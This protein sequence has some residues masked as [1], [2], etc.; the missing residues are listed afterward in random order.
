MVLLLCTNYSTGKEEGCLYLVLLDSFTLS[1]LV[2]KLEVCYRRKEI[3]TSDITSP[4]LQCW[5]FLCVLYISKY[6]THSASFGSV[7]FFYTQSTTKSRQSSTLG[8]VLL[9]V[10]QKA[11]VSTQSF[12]LL[13]CF[14]R[15][16]SEFYNSGISKIFVLYNPNLF[17][18]M[19][20]LISP[21][22]RQW[23]YQLKLC[24][25]TAGVCPDVIGD[26]LEQLALIPCIYHSQVRDEDIYNIYM[27]WHHLC[28]VSLPVSLSVLSV[29]HRKGLPLY[30]RVCHVLDFVLNTTSGN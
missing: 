29:T 9:Y 19:K 2:F 15:S 14:S 27:Q 3:N 30:A 20:K 16:S 26:W 18:N 13:F 7:L 10:Y 1:L 28:W 5:W 22:Q 6:P 21:I 4:L 8:S 24:C 12:P 25:A 23:I 11:I 17:H